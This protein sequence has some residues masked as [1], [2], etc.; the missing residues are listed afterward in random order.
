MID[1]MTQEHKLTI[2]FFNE[3]RLDIF[4]I[5]LNRKLEELNLTLKDLDYRRKQLFFTICG[6]MDAIL[7]FLGDFSE[8]WGIREMGVSKFARI[9][10]ISNEEAEEWYKEIS[11]YKNMIMSKSSFESKVLTKIMKYTDIQKLEYLKRHFMDQLD[12]LIQSRIDTLLGNEGEYEAFLNR[13]IEKQEL[14]NDL[15]DGG[16]EVDSALLTRIIGFI[17]NS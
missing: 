10:E 5:E 9:M 2:T 17:E 16:K 13:Q 4:K 11:E 14:L 12:E 7:L 3:E 8:R 15:K 1:S 6:T